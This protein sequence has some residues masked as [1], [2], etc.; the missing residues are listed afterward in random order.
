MRTKIQLSF[1]ELPQEAHV[2]LR[3]SLLEHISQI[4]EHT[5]SAIVTQVFMHILSQNL[6]YFFFCLKCFTIFFNNFKFLPV[7]LCLALADLVLQMS[8]WQKPVVDLINKFGTSTANLWPLLE[9]LTVLPEEANS[10]SLR[11]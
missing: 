4:N 10:R 3:D 5:N 9:I 11:Y 8:S 6:F 2:S 7:Q 1:H